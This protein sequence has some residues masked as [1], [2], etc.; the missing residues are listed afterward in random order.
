MDTGIV[1]WVLPAG[2]ALLAGGALAIYTR[3]IMPAALGAM[4]AFVFVVFAFTT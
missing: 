3:R 4:A 2:I 1:D